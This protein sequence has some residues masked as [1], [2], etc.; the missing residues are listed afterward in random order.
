MLISDSHRFL[1]IHVDKAAG[2]SLRDALRPWSRQPLHSPLARRLWWL[3][4]LCRVGGLH[5]RTVF[6]EH[7]T[8][9]ALRRCLPAA[10]WDRHFKFA[11]VRNP[12]DRLVSRYNF[13]LRNTTHRH[14]ALVKS[15]PDF[16][17]YLEWEI[18]RGNQVQHPFVTDRHGRLLIDFVGRFENLE[19]DFATICRRLGLD[20]TLPHTN[21]SPH[22][23]YREYYTDQWRDLVAQHVQRDCDLFGYQA[24]PCPGRDGSRHLF[25]AGL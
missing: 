7:I 23:D 12:W 2:S 11:F 21:R 20:A 24:P 19:T 16:G 17:R 22:K 8:A 9:A 18:R 10:E 4:P 15:F 25:G 1:F 5:R 6:P 3:G 14:H 13:L